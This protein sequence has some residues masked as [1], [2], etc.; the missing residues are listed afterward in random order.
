MTDR[1]E[2][3]LPLDGRESLFDHAPQTYACCSCG[4]SWV[5]DKH[6]QKWLKKNPGRSPLGPCCAYGGYFG[7]S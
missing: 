5:A 1:N 6:D 2:T 7:G 4:K 3:A